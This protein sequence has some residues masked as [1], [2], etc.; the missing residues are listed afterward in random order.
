[1]SFS[2]RVTIKWVPNDF[3]EKSSTMVLSSPKGQFVDI[4]ILKDHY[5]YH[6]ASHPFVTD[7]FQMATVGVEK[8]I[9]GTSKIEFECSINSVDIA[10]SIKTNKPLDECRS[11]PDIGD[12]SAI[13]GCEDRQETGAMENPETG[14]RTEY[15]EIWRSLDP[16]KHTPTVEAREPKEL[17][18]HL[19]CHVL[20]VVG[21]ENYEGRLVRLGNWLQALVYDKR[22]AHHPLHISRQYYNGKSWE[23]LIDY[24]FI[25]LPLDFKGELN[26]ETTADGLT[27]KCTELS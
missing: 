13:E 14:L 8:P 23:I 18:Q 5:P 7:L 2:T 20:D 27:W 11:A 12:F 24:G 15:V 4:R 10:K 21:N 16:L 9:A 25:E 22:N 1:M 17:S 3:D 26:D 19:N 6:E